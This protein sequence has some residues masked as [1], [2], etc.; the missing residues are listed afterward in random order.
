MADYVRKETAQF[1]DYFNGPVAGLPPMGGIPGRENGRR[2][3]PG[4]SRM[5]QESLFHGEALARDPWGERYGPWIVLGFAA[6]FS[7]FLIGMLIAGQVPGKSFLL[8]GSSDIAQFIGEFIGLLFC[9]RIALRLYWVSARMKRDLLQQSGQ[10]RSA[11]EMAIAHSEA[12][13]ARRTFLAWTALTIAIALYASGQAI[14]TSYD[15]RMNSASV[16]FPG[17]YDI[18]FVASYPFFLIGTILLTRRNKAAVGQAR[19]VLDAL[20][21]IGTALALSWFFL[22]SPEIAGLAQAP[23][24]GAA[25]LSIYFPAGDLFLVAVGAFLMFS[26]LANRAQQS[27]FMLLCAGLFFLAITDSLLSFY[28]L[29]SGFNTGTLQDVLWP[30]SMSLIGLA[31][32]EY[33]RSVAREQENEGRS[34]N[35][36]IPVATAPNQFT[37]LSMTAQTIAPFILVLG[38]SAILLTDV[39]PKG[40][41]TLIQADVVTLILVVIIVIRQALTLLENNRLAMQM[42]GELVISRR[43][44]QVSRREADEAT[45]TAQEK[46]ALD[47]GIASLRDVHAR[48]ARGDIVARAP[49]TPGPLLPIAISLNLMLDRISAL[50]QRGAKY[51]QLAHECRILQQGVE[52][53]GEGK[54]PWPTNQQMP[55]GAPEMRSVYLGL[56][57]IQRLQENHWRRVMS[58]LAS[59]HTLTARIREALEELQHS[60]LFKDQ[61]QANFERMVLDRVVREID[62]LEQQQGNMLGQVTQLSN[63]RS[64]STQGEQQDKEAASASTK[65]AVPQVAERKNTFGLRPYQAYQL[66][67]ISTDD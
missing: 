18:G 12:Q 34:K 35:A 11:N 54:P 31:A 9:A 6:L 65:L 19:L 67:R 45:R 57:H 53:L 42:R 52:R 2:N 47:E 40:G 58:A 28:S 36:G 20:A 63:T 13:A 3:E 21:V 30:L 4:A 1:A 32:I 50:S 27:V 15:I 5:R 61:T 25:F 56:A 14:W 33:P 59:M 62:L 37:Q 22:L 60:H 44:L 16:P 17:I 24:G 39:A 38:T 66:E 23:S 48:V 55:Q 51:D 64:T 8:K 49:A 10:R 26:P 29:S 46:Q 43:E 41:I 7:L